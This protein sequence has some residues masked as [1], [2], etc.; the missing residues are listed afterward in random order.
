MKRTFIIAIA[1]E[2]GGVGKTTIATNLAVYLKAMREDFPVTIASFDNHFSVDKMFAIDPQVK[3]TVA[4]LFEDSQNEALAQLGQYGVQYIPSSQ[5]LIPPQRPPSWL[6]SKLD[7]LDLSGILVVDTRPILDWFA[8]AAVLAADLIIV[9][10]KDRAALVNAAKFR[11]LLQSVNRTDN[12]W[13][14]PSLIDTR[15]RLNAD[16]KVYE[17]LVHS[18]REQEYQV[19]E[20]LISKSPKVESLASGFSSSIPSVLTHAK[21]TAV[22]SQLKQL[23]DF[24][25]EHVDAVTNTALFCGHNNGASGERRNQESPRSKLTKICPICDMGSVMTLGHFFL[26]LRSRR[27]GF[28]H[29]E[30]FD[31]VVNAIPEHF[32]QEGCAVAFSFDGPGF[33]GPECHLSTYRLDSAGSLCENIE[34]NEK[35]A[36]TVK[37]ILAKLSGHPLENICRET[38][39]IE[40][41]MNPAE[42]DMENISENPLMLRRRKMLQELRHAGLFE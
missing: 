14:L 40:M 7:A 1:S 30:C 5:K 10:I 25:F 8:E 32:E 9:P 37:E 29:G 33:L 12:L 34:L 35:A 3:Q 24:V 13:L 2:K 27:W 22:Y 17:F 21:K 31:N 23:A 6:R 38:V 42:Q 4:N 18:A 11:Q 26:N 16:V 19:M 28:I 36:Q 15:A 20:L 41:K 39:L